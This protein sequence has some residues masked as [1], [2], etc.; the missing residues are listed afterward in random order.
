MMTY[1]SVKEYA[2]QMGVTRETVLRWL[3]HGYIAGAQRTGPL[4]HWRIPDLL[5]QSHSSP[6]TQIDL[7]SADSGSTSH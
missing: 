5:A 3:H 7:A 1:L 4:G 6:S 2:A